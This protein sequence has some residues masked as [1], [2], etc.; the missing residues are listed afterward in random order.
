MNVA[1][2]FGLERLKSICEEFIG[3]GV[4]IENVAW[5]GY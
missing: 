2:E 3:R 5:Y 4:D 1:N